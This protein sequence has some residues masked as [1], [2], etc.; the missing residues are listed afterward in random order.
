[1]SIQYIF[2]SKI[3]GKTKTYTEDLCKK[4][5]EK[6]TSPEKADELEKIINDTVKN[7]K[8]LNNEVVDI[9][10]T[11]QSTIPIVSGDFY[12]LIST[13]SIQLVEL[14]ILTFPEEYIFKFSPEKMKEDYLTPNHWN[15]TLCWY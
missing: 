2:S 11:D 7:A 13:Y 1:M 6:Y 9:R 3:K 8:L 12:K 10:H 5:S 4:L 14:V 15:P